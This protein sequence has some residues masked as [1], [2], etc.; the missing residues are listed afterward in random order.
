MPSANVANHHKPQPFGA[1]YDRYD[2]VHVRRA[3]HRISIYYIPAVAVYNACALRQ[4]ETLCPQGRFYH[5]V[6]VY[7]RGAVQLLFNGSLDT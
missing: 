1:V 2:S 6:P 5:V 3:Y 7:Y 4:R